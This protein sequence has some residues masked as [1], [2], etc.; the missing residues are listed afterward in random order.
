M[1]LIEAEYVSK[2]Q[3]VIKKLSVGDYN[4][5]NI[6]VGR[7]IYDNYTVPDQDPSTPS[8]LDPISLRC[9]SWAIRRLK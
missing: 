7:Q 1:I 5:G 3:S 6:P 8:T 9:Q 2:V 4:S